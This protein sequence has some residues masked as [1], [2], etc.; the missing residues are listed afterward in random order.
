MSK[1]D[2]TT[3]TAYAASSSYDDGNLN[4]TE[5]GEEGVQ[6]RS[7]MSVSALCCPTISEAEISPPP[8]QAGVIA[9][10]PEESK[11]PNKVSKHSAD[12]TSVV[13]TVSSVAL[14][15]FLHPYGY[16]RE[17]ASARAK[18]ASLL[19][20][21]GAT[22]RMPHCLAPVNVLATARP[23]TYS[24]EERRLLATRIYQSA[25]S[26]TT[27][28]RE[29]A[30]KRGTHTPISSSCVNVNLRVSIAPEHP[31]SDSKTSYNGADLNRGAG[32]EPASK[33][34]DDRWRRIGDQGQ[35]TDETGANTNCNKS[36]SPDEHDVLAVRA[37]GGMLVRP[38][39]LS[40]K[41]KPVQRHAV[42]SD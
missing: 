16:F 34:S 19:F 37:N 6:E 29:G 28:S 5:S 18:A 12:S 40:A 33:C 27:F 31:E 39:Y 2:I 25:E 23:M 11:D 10:A 21:D 14:K 15:P 17:E 36:S 4:V 22:M 30:T 7:S 8:Q 42:L 24:C 35:G 9:N 1:I 3:A 38:F 41:I 13:E 20:G 26:S 32:G